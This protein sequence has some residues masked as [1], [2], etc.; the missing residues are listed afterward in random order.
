MCLANGSHYHAHG[1]L[2]KHAE[3]DYL[4]PFTHVTQFAVYIGQMCDHALLGVSY[5]VIK[6]DVNRLSRG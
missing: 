3:S 5:Y 6:R 1:W 2:N 4:Q